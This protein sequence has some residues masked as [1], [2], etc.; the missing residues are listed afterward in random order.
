MLFLNGDLHWLPG[1]RRHR[2]TPTRPTGPTGMIV[3]DAL[4]HRQFAIV[5]DGV[6]H[7]ILPGALCGHRS[8]GRRSDAVLRGSLHASMRSD[9]VRTARAKGL[10]ERVVLFRHALRNS[11]SAA[12]SMTGLQVGLMFAGVVVIETVFAWP[13][14]GLYTEQS[15]PV[16][17]FPAIAG[18]TLVL[19][20]VL[21][22]HQRAGR[23]TAGAG[24]PPGR[25]RVTSGGDAIHPSEYTESEKEDL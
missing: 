10:I 16:A 18:V 11:L 19:G 3:L 6:E 23:R 12:L 4:L 25:P 21:R 1:E 24:R 8:G 7:L 17:D 2:G 13:G 9:F 5:W 20:V 14:I 22:R 15:I